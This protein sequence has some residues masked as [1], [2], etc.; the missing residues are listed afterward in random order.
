MEIYVSTKSN[1]AYKV[2][3]RKVALRESVRKILCNRYTVKRCKGS[4]S[5]YHVEETVFEIVLTRIQLDEHY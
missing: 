1:L 4:S 5:K 2:T 3:K